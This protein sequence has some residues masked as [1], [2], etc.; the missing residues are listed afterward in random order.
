MRVAALDPDCRAWAG[1]GHKRARVQ[2]YTKVV[3]RSAAGTLS[4]A[5]VQ[6][7]V[8][9]QVGLEAQAA[10]NALIWPVGSNCVRPV[11]CDPPTAQATAI[12]RISPAGPV[13]NVRVSL[14]SSD[15]PRVRCPGKLRG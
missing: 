1:G 13:N 12:A 15:H 5:G 4:V 7:V 11:N 3:P 6:V 2:I 9:V 8:R 10:G 14:G